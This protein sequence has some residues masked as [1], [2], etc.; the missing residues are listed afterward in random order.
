MHPLLRTLLRLPMLI[1]DIPFVQIGTRTSQEEKQQIAGSLMPGDI[2]LITDRLFPLWQLTLQ[3]LCRG[4]YCHTGIYEGNGLVI[5]ATTFHPSGHG[6]VRTATDAFLSGYKTCCVL[7]PPYTSHRECL[8]ALAYA[9]RQLG[10][11]Y[12][13]DM[14]PDNNGAMYC[15]K[16]AAGTLQAAGITTPTKH[17]LGREVYVPDD[18]MNIR[19]MQ[20]V[21]GRRRL[22]KSWCLYLLPVLIAFLVLPGVY[23]LGLLATG[24]LAGWWQHGRVQKQTIWN[25]YEQ[26][27]ETETHYSLRADSGR[28]PRRLPLLP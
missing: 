21:H 19:G 20:A 3:A 9:A 5:E 25:Y 15:S 12:D 22:S 1:P 14:S 7:R 4:D 8:Q 6:V 24:I 18:F 13:Y 10:K 28:N 23:A 2:L 26:H 17:C 27:H 11:P 16:L